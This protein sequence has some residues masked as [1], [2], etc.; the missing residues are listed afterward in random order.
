[1]FGVP[2]Y[3]VNTPYRYPPRPRTSSPAPV[4]GGETLLLA[5]LVLFVVLVEALLPPNPPLL[6]EGRL[7]PLPL[8]CGAVGGL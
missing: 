4:G 7:V 3:S 6:H 5:L 8:L 1:M 2:K